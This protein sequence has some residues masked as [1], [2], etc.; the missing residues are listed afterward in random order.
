MENNIDKL[1][2]SKLGGDATPYDPA[3]WGRMAALIDEDEN[4][5]RGAIPPVKRNWKSYLGLALLFIICLVGVWQ[6]DTISNNNSALNTTSSNDK[7][8]WNELNLDLSPTKLLDEYSSSSKNSKESINNRKTTKSNIESQNLTTNTSEFTKGNQILEEKN[9]SIPF[10]GNSSDLKSKLSNDESKRSLRPSKNQPENSAI[11]SLKEDILASSFITQ[12]NTKGA[13]NIEGDLSNNKNSK[14]SNVLNDTY[15]LFGVKNEN[16]TDVSLIVSPP[17]NE[18]NTLVQF[19]IEKSSTLRKISSEFPYINT[20]T[21][22]LIN[23][24]REI[25]PLMSQIRN[26]TKLRIGLI[27][28][29][30]VNQGYFSQFGFS[31]DYFLNPDWSLSSGVAFEYSKYNNGAII[32]VN[33]KL[34]SF[35][36][37]IVERSL[38]INKRTAVNLPIQVNKTFNNLSIS[39][40]ISLNY[41]IA[42]NG[43][44]DDT[45]GNIRSIWVTNDAFS[46]LS[47]NYQVG[48]SYLMNRNI[49]INVGLS[50]RKNIIKSDVNLMDTGSK[51]YPNL[52]FNYLIAKY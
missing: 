24:Y 9:L 7:E 34:Y 42:G 27:T 22:E 6:F 11:E 52:G 51:I 29:L 44:I 31:M 40:G 15:R 36:S 25:V 20:S 26:S 46:P 21:D 45:E 38:K 33:D 35:G 2:K 30:A 43:T 23:E 8:S 19:D 39:G 41:H 13:G 1:F 16:N 49:E 3:A 5:N 47:L 32:S 14:K 4:L 37:S 12:T 10:K 18:I 50:Y 28:N 48:A 17:E